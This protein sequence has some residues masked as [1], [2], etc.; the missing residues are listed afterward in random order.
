MDR[1]PWANHGILA[2]TVVVSL[3][4]FT[5]PSVM[6]DLAGIKV[7]NIG[8][9][10]LDVSLSTENLPLP[11]LAV[12]SSLLH[13]DM[14][15]LLGNMLFLWIFGNA[16]NYKFGHLGYLAL[17]VG[18]A[19]VGGMAHYLLT[20]TPVVGA[21]GAINGVMAAFLIFFP[22]NDI[23]VVFVIW[24]RPGIGKLS[25]GWIIA[26]W[27]VCDIVLLGLDA[28][29]SVA[30]YSHMGGFAVGLATAYL[31]ARMGWIRPTPDEQTLLDLLGIPVRGKK[32]A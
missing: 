6:H 25:S 11:V 7:T 13:A 27:V 3:L 4:A 20:G 24:I 8:G 14:L 10:V 22:R 19:V 29:G 26:L 18:A 31:C 12:T 5:D 30:L 23:T 17:Y 16:I 28:G 9:Y 32:S 21:S 2:L 1:V 15:H